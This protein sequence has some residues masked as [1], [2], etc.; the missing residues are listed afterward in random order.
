MSFAIFFVLSIIVL[1]VE[2]QS[3]FT[4]QSGEKRSHLLRPLEMLYRQMAA[5]K[6]DR[7]K[8]F[9]V[10]KRFDSIDGLIP[11]YDYER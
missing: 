8:R 5:S 7:F 4:S 3:A 6:A 1:T 10:F 9:D 11:V 2:P